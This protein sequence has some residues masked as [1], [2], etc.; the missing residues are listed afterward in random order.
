MERATLAE[1]M[2][3][4]GSVATNDFNRSGVA[5]GAVIG[6]AFVTAALSLTLLALGTG[7]G[8]SAA[9]PWANSGA[10]AS[11][12]RWTAIVWLILM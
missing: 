9:S 6:G 10:S 1:T 5:W 4:N 3:T 8:L 12:I 2:V 11:A 7:I